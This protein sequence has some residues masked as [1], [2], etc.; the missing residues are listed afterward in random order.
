MREILALIVLTVGAAGFLMLKDLLD[1]DR[2]L[3]GGGRWNA[4]SMACEADPG[5]VFQHNGRE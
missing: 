2:C 4:F 1:V 5:F 3:D